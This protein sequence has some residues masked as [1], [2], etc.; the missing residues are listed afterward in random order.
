M[1]T[2][3]HGDAAV[4]RWFARVATE[5]PFFDRTVFGEYLAP[6]SPS[7][8]AAQTLRKRGHTTRCPIWPEKGRRRAM[9]S[10]TGWS[11]WW[12]C[13]PRRCDMPA[14]VFV[15]CL[16]FFDVEHSI[17]MVTWRGAT[18]AIY[19]RLTG[20]Y[21]DRILLDCPVRGVIRRAE[22]VLVQDVRGGTER[23][24]QVILACNVDQSLAL[25]ARPSARERRLLGAVRYDTGPHDEAVAHTRTIRSCPTTACRCPRAGAPSYATTATGPTRGVCKT[26]VTRYTRWRSCRSARGF[27]T[28]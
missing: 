18:R 17:P 10:C 20:D 7:V 5:R 14:S 9:R 23:F 4:L 27:V 21:A 16:D 1:G 19:Q 11:C 15:R 8:Q 13:L 26:G 24:D 28:L 6:A 3:P 12:P 2:R 22:G 25:L